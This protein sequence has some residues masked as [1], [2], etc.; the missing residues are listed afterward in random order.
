MRIIINI[1]ERRFLKANLIRVREREGVIFIPQ[2][3]P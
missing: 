2:S 1:K 3:V